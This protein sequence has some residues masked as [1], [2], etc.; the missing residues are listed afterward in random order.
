MS[1]KLEISDERPWYTNNDVVSGNV[2]LELK[3]SVEITKI[4]VSLVGVC[5]VSLSRVDDVGQKFLDHVE[6]NLTFLNYSTQVFPPPGQDSGSK[7]ALRAGTHSWPFEFEFPFEAP[8]TNA[9]LP[10]SLS[11]IDPDKAYIRYYL[12]AEMDKS[13][14]AAIKNPFLNDI[15]TAITFLPSDDQQVLDA[16]PTY[17]VFQAQTSRVQSNTKTVGGLF[18]RFLSS[19][20]HDRSPTCNNIAAF[21]VSSELLFTPGLEFTIA[22][23]ALDLLND[24]NI[25]VYSLR[26]ELVSRTYLRAKNLEETKDD[27]IVLF[28][29]SNLK[30]RAGDLLSQLDN[31]SIKV[32]ENVPP[33]FESP[34]IRRV[35]RLDIRLKWGHRPSS[36]QVHKAQ[37]GRIAWVR[38]GMFGSP[39]YETGEVIRTERS[40]PQAK[41]YYKF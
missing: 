37:T 3:S 19:V 25:C 38:S 16:V 9:I 10:P 29:R 11:D 39:S 21:E 30:L 14:M 35:Y 6:E 18:S 4:V 2:V 17:G 7:Y 13:S 8:N 20:A 41:W 23:N 24:E 1:F 34:N 27:I 5:K 26:I 40:Y 32:P 22:V 33:S 12:K 15:F 28:D 31:P 36:Q